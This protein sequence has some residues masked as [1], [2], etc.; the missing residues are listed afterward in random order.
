[1]ARLLRMPGISA[2]AEEVVFLEWC[3]ELGSQVGA[4]EAI[5]TVET[6]K[7]NVDIEA[8][9]EAVLWRTLISPG[10]SVAVG[11]PIAVLAGVNE[12]LGDEAEI[13]AS[14]G[15]AVG[16]VASVAPDSADV[17]DSPQV[18]M[19]EES[20][21]E[22][23]AE[24][25]TEV[26][27]DSDANVGAHGR[28]FASPLARKLARENNIAI[29]DVVGTG[30]GQRIVRLDIER[31]IASGV[32]S[33][34]ESSASALLASTSSSGFT[35]IPHTGMR[36]AIARALTASKS[37]VPHFYLEATCRVDSLIALR[38]QIN[39][40]GSVKVS[41]NDFV[42]KAVAKALVDVPEMNV[43][44]MDECV[45]RFESVD[46]S[47]AIGSESGLVT[48][49]IRGAENL[50]LARISDQVRDFAQRANEGRLKQHELEGGSF[51]VSN[52]GMFGVENFS[53]ILN[54]PQAGILAVGAVQ[55][56]PVVIDGAL[57][58]GSVMKVTL[59][60]DHRPV[61][62]VMAATWLGRFQTLIENP[63]LMFM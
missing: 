8:D 41:V 29:E 63:A 30:P 18:S 62:G 55:S 45:R 31:A 58:V 48:P 5:A 49:V 15:L 9:D 17:P 47:V 27:P 26:T 25:M 10:D 6:E 42:L 33:R 52:L 19:L 12:E 16:A 32:N 1:M 40:D 46:I 34:A 23:V 57:A 22:V 35:D 14:L 44:W 54:P 39:E 43:I 3:A 2:D 20:A 11:A 24:T 53:A 7:A 36:R 56:Q 38:R 51:S 59:S 28:V 37:Q 21:P 50:T 4:G 61:D 60:V 13:L